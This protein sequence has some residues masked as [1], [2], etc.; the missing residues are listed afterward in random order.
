MSSPLVRA[1]ETADLL[2]AAYV[3]M[4][5][6]EIMEELAPG[7]SQEE[8]LAR[9]V[10]QGN[11]TVVLVGHEP[12]LGHLAGV[13]VT[14]AQMT[15]PL[16]KAGACGIE[17]EGTVASGQGELMWFATPRLLRALGS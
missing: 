3:P 13:L 10:E 15:L 8:I 2:A 9:I 16:K 12:G 17:L 6:V 7:R 11:G 1:K 5:Q 4:L 14:G